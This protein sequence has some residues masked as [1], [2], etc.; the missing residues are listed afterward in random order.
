MNEMVQRLYD[1]VQYV[2][3]SMLRRMAEDAVK[4][5]TEEGLATFALQILPVR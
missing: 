3:K 5:G 1:L 2:L 4:I